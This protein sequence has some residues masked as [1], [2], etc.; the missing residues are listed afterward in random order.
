MVSA[1]SNR[2]SCRVRSQQWCT[3]AS[4]DAPSPSTA[5]SLPHPRPEVGSSRNNNRVRQ[6]G[7]PISSCVVAVGQFGRATVFL[8]FQPYQGKYPGSLVDYAAL[9][10]KQAGEIESV[11]PLPRSMRSERFPAR[12][13]RRTD[14]WS[15]MN[16]ISFGCNCVRRQSVMSSPG[17]QFDRGPVC[18]YRSTH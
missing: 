17:R 1:S 16:A 3:S 8:P 12:N 6:P 2:I 13:I 18:I 10:C 5:L 15:G 9:P 11:L 14:S 4:D 7:Y